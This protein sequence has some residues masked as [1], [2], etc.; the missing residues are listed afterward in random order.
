MDTSTI[1]QLSDVPQSY[2]DVP[3]FVL[4]WPGPSSAQAPWSGPGVECVIINWW[5]QFD[6]DLDGTRAGREAESGTSYNYV[7][8]G[9]SDQLSVLKRWAS[10]QL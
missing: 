8:E 6:W 2:R 7:N 5:R 3:R 4:G 10:V 1:V 9:V